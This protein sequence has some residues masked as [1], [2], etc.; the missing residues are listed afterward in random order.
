MKLNAKLSCERVCFFCVFS[1]AISLQFICVLSAISLC[2][3][4]FSLR[5][6]CRFSRLITDSSQSTNQALTAD[7][8]S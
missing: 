8:S 5:F 7:T 3:S 6:V 1:A 4:V 2:F